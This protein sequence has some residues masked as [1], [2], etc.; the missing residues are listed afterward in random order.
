MKR[1]NYRIIGNEPVSEY[2]GTLHELLSGAHYLEVPVTSDLEKAVNTFDQLR[3]AQEITVNG[4]I[5]TYDRFRDEFL[6]PAEAVHI[7]YRSAEYFAK[8]LL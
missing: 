8:K 4:K 1:V 5:F 6:N 2:F 7:S 3:S